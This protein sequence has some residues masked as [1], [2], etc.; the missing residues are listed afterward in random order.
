MRIRLAV[1]ADQKCWRKEAL[2]ASWTHA[3]S[4]SPHFTSYFTG[5]LTSLV[6]CHWHL[7][8]VYL[9]NLIL[10]FPD[11][12]SISHF[13]ST[14]ILSFFS[15]LPHLFIAV[16]CVSSYRST[17]TANTMQSIHGV[18]DRDREEKHE[19]HEHAENV[20]AYEDPF[21]NEEFAEVQY[22]TL[23]WW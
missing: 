1:T 18:D 3:I 9:I 13:L 17:S 6:S 14:F 12:L 19:K 21:G 7:L 20:P 8:G 2:E 4:L 5:P 10:L 15:V 23:R 11:L 16:P 22:R